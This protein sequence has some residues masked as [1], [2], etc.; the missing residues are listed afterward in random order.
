MVFPL[1]IYVAPRFETGDERHGWL[2]HVQAI[3]KGTLDETLQLEYEWY[4]V[5]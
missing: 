3:G 2:N 5:R 1:T 4:E